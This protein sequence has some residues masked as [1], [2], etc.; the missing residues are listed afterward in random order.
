MMFGCLVAVR[1]V[2]VAH[3]FTPTNALADPQSYTGVSTLKPIA[4]GNDL[5]FAEG[6]GHAIRMLTYNDGYRA[7]TPA[8]SS[9]LS[10][11]LFGPGRDIVRWAI[12]KALTR[13]SGVSGRWSAACVHLDQS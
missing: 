13:L 7:Y 3:R 2:Q 11:H 12:K 6:K 9:I 8:I 10:S 5:L 4:I 1:Q